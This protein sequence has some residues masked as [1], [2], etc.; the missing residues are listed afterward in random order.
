MR[1]LSSKVEVVEIQGGRRP[2]SVVN[3][4]SVGQTTAWSGRGIRAIYHQQLSVFII[5]FLIFCGA[6]TLAADLPVR[7]DP[8]QSAVNSFSLIFSVPPCLRGRF[9]F[10][11]QCKSVVYLR[12][13]SSSV[14][15]GFGFELVR[16]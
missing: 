1:V 7:D 10:S 8:R 9:S 2:K 11:D 16:V 5:R 15:Q 4:D 3:G 6:G 14:F 13:L 12:C